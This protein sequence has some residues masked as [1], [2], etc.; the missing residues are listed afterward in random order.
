MGVRLPAEY[1][2]VEWI[3][4]VRDQSYLD[5]PLGRISFPYFKCVLCNPTQDSWTGLRFSD[6]NSNFYLIVDRLNVASPYFSFS[7]NGQ[8]AVTSNQSVYFPS[9]VEYRPL[10]GLLVNNIS[11][12]NMALSDKYAT[13][14]LLGKH[15]ANIRQ[16]RLW[17][18][19]LYDAN[20]IILD[21]VPCYRKSD[22][23]PGMY[24]LVTKQFF[25]NAG[26]GEFLVGP[27]V[28]DSINPW[29]VAR[30]RMLMY[31]APELYPIGTDIITM[32]IG[33]DENNR[34]NFNLGYVI[35]DTGEYTTGNGAASPVFMPV[36][37]NYRY[38]KSR[39]TADA[40]AGRIIR[41]AYYDENYNFISA[42]S[43][44]NL[45]V[46]D[47]PALP[48]N[49]KYARIQTINNLTN[50]TIAIFRIS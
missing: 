29:L 22:S 12:G 23:E 27:D 1:Q 44:N 11:V 17:Y 33:R 38:Q 24:D 32:Y 16:T 39:I 9:I 36:N 41:F 37:P 4:T 35:T 8:P 42:V 18:C 6:S 45:N 19:K 26:T 48:S 13:Q 15:G 50:F 43:Y 10:D 25:T 3:Q 46:V 5:I 28:I 40:I 47:L 34:A 7:A 49:A 2:E 30:R 14:L 20:Q 31:K 21:L